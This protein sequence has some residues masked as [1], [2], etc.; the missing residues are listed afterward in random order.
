MKYWL[1]CKNLDHTVK[2]NI[3]M[4]TL[5]MIYREGVDEGMEKGIEQGIE[6]GI[7]K[8]IEK[9]QKDSIRKLLMRGVEPAQVAYLLDLPM[10][11]VQEVLAEDSKKS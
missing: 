8:G 5:E 11:L 4:N 1:T 7:Q 2:K 6:Q 9:S 10:T 3:A